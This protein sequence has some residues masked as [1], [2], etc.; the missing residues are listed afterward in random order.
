VLQ[1]ALT[2]APSSADTHMADDQVK[3]TVR[4]VDEAS[5]PLK[6]SKEALAAL[7]KEAGETAKGIEKAGA[8]WTSVFKGMAAWD[9][10]K[11]GARAAAGFFQDSLRESIDAAAGM[12]QVEQNI[13]NA[14]LSFKELAPQIQ[15]AGDAAIQLGFDDDEAMLSLS[16]LTLVTGNYA[17]ALKLQQLSMDLARSKGIGLAEAT[18]LVTQ[19]T[20]GSGRVLKQYGIDLDE[21]ATVADQLSTLQDKLRGS[22]EAFATTTAGRLAIVNQEWMNI[23][24]TVG[25]DLMPITESFIGLMKDGMPAI[26]LVLSGVTGELTAMLEAMRGIAAIPGFLREIGGSLASPLSFL[27]IDLLKEKPTGVLGEDYMKGVREDAKKLGEQ[28]KETGNIAAKSFV[29]IGGAA[30]SA[31]SD[32]KP[33]LSQFTSLEKKMSD[34]RKQSEADAVKSSLA[35]LDVRGKASALYVEQERKVLDIQK[36]IEDAEKENAKKGDKS[37]ESFQA[38][39]V[40]RSE[41]AAAE[42]DLQGNAIVPLTMSQDVAEARRRA[43]L[44]DFGRAMEDVRLGEIQRNIEYS[45]TQS[46]N[47]AALAETRSQIINFTFNGDVNDK[48]A[49]KRDIIDAL[50][51]QSSMAAAGL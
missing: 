18:T 16:R 27:G 37:F 4:A 49:L 25:D 7:K 30:K 23:K 15:A 34:L 19:V 51:R 44:S 35:G 38:L 26:K 12:V 43:S 41:K 5:A 46:A 17:Q 2:G 31:A 32:L 22:T 6:K 29:G 3:I 20:A 45:G 40:L 39:A 47:A 42:A 24:Q 48:E 50:N 28:I 11:T 9:L 8:S 13:K 36:Q 1:G 33:L 10:L 21:T 14:G